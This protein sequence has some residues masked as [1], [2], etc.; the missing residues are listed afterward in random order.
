MMVRPAAQ[1]GVRWLGM[2]KAGWVGVT[3]SGTLVLLPASCVLSVTIPRSFADADIEPKCKAECGIRV[4]EKIAVTTEESRSIGKVT[5]SRGGME[6]PVGTDY[7][8]RQSHVFSQPYGVAVY[9]YATS[10]EQRMGAKK[11]GEI[12]WYFRQGDEVFHGKHFPQSPPTKEQLVE[13][14]LVVRPPNNSLQTGPAQAPAAD[15][16]R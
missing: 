7:V 12:T 8:L 1:H 10:L 6:W 15:L 14:A 13:Q 3:I 2:G 16:E 11:L 9:R 4:F 5:F